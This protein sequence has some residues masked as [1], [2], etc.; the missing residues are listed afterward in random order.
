MVPTAQRGE[1]VSENPFS[2]IGLGRGILLWVLFFLICF[3]LGYATLNR[4]DPRTSGIVDS[5]SYYEIVA[6]GPTARLEH[7]QFRVLVPFL[8]KPFYW[9]AK[10]R[11]RTWNPVFFGLLMAN[12]LL[13]ATTALLLARIGHQQAR[14]LA[15]ALFGATIYLLNFDVTNLRLAG[16]IDAGE[17]CFLMFMVWSLFK[18]RWWLLP[19]WGLLGALTKESFV[20]YSTILAS[21]WWLVSSRRH[22]SW[23]SRI[24]WVAVMVMVEFAA[25]MILQASL[26]RQVL[27]PWQFAATL[28]AGPGYVRRFVGSLVDRQS[29]YDFIW[30]LPLGV[31]RLKRLPRPWVVACATTVLCPLVLSAYH[32]AEPGTWGRAAFSIAGPLLSLSVALLFSGPAHSLMSPDRS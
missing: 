3:G 17:G 7:V 5:V 9:L 27:W 14:D 28:G 32:N 10:G 8:A 31:W 1:A 4:Y 25:V 18:E 11:V 29:W 22:V 24:V 23:F 15:V 19:L 13:V 21:T 30:L 12:S 20:P 26:T 16:L 2:R 6:R